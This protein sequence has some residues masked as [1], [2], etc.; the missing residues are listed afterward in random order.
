MET[1]MLNLIY[2]HN[3]LIN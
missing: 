1:K 2:T 3:Y